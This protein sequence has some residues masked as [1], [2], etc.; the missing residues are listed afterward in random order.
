MYR[1]FLIN[2]TLISITFLCSCRQGTRSEHQETEKQIAGTEQPAMHNSLTAEQI[3]EGWVLLFDGKS[4]DAWRSFGADSL[5]GGWVAE[6]GNLVALGE[7]TDLSGDIITREKFR[8]FE[9]LVEWKISPGGNSG[10]MYLVKEEGYDVPYATGPEYQIIDDIGFPEKLEPWQTTGANY[11]MHP[12]VN[13]RVK[14]VGKYNKS[15]IRVKDGHVEHWLNGV[16]VVE[17][18]L[19]TDE[20]KEKVE[21]GKWKDYP[22]YGTA[23]EGHICLQ[24][25]GS[26]VWFRNIKIR[27]LE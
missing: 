3:E 21:Q 7:G 19:W 14:P 1:A 5:V 22:G 15:M 8:D 25:H 17:Y 18:E 20:W 16:K 9:F 12:P 13:P 11:A 23:R 24:D 6:D 27:E 4:L 26:K 10:I 2:I